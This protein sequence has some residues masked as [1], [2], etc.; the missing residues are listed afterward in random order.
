MKTIRDSGKITKIKIR[1]I[2]QT[3]EKTEDIDESENPVVT[4]KV[5]STITRWVYDGCM[6]TY[7]EID[8]KNT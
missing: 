6:P 3:I 7:K 4:E 1:E 8:D 5:K 2:V